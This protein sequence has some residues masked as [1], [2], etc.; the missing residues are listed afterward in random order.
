MTVWGRYDALYCF[1]FLC[2]FGTVM[3][4][5]GD[6]PDFYVHS[7]QHEIYDFVTLLT[8]ARK[9]AANAFSPLGQTSE[10]SLS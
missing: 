2:L 6:I 7:S 1:S 10:E 5:A 4:S 9:R 3:Q 8:V